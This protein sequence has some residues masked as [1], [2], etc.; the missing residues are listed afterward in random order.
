MIYV[1]WVRHVA[2]VALVVA[3]A[4]CGNGDDDAADDAAD[5]DATTRACDG[6][7]AVDEATKSGDELAIRDGFE[8]LFAAASESGNAELT[9]L[10]N[11]LRGADGNA[12]FAL[13]LTDLTDYC[14]QL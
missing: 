12:A 8:D 10:V 5:S 9:S 2:V 13:A 7:A 11:D 1:Q 14:D 4:A 3:A 6:L